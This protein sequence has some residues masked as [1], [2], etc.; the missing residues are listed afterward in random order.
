MNPIEIFIAESSKLFRNIPYFI[1]LIFDYWNPNL[2]KKIGHHFIVPFVKK[3]SGYVE[4]IKVPIELLNVYLPA[5]RVV[6]NGKIVDIKKFGEVRELSFLLNKSANTPQKIKEIPKLS[7]YFKRIFKE[8]FHKE[9]ERQWV[10]K[11][12]VGENIYYFPSTIIGTFFYFLSH[13]FTTNLF[14][15]SLSRE[16]I[17][18]GTNP[19]FIQLKPGYSNQYRE[20]VSLYLYSTNPEAKENYDSIG[21]RHIKKRIYREQDNKSNHQ[22]AFKCSFPVSG[23]WELK[24]RVLPIAD[25]SFFVAEILYV[26]TY[27]L[28]KTDFIELRVKSFR[29]R[30]R[31]LF[32]SSVVKSKT[33]KVYDSNKY[34]AV[35]ELPE[36]VYFQFSS[37][38]ADK[39]VNIIRKEVEDEDGNLFFSLIPIPRQIN[40]KKVL[41]N[42]K[43]QS[44]NGDAKGLRAKIGEK[45]TRDTENRVFDLEIVKELMDQVAKV[46]GVNMDYIEFIPKISVSADPK[47]QLELCYPDGNRRTVGVFFFDLSINKKVTA[48]FL[49]QKSLRSFITS[50]IIVGK[51]RLEYPKEVEFFFRTFVKV[52]RKSF[53]DFCHKK[54]FNVHLKKPIQGNSRKDWENWVERMVDILE[55][56]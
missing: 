47:K 46:L 35:E 42:V 12:S 6:Y 53:K 2:D 19:P 44:N 3:R 55:L 17:S 45:A 20:V 22:Y 23:E 16:I 43:G 38:P 36:T 39:S 25:K 49:D 48:I 11:V 56:E 7:N 4:P 5:Q 14:Q 41:S 27:K 26:N 31:L 8:F 24:A 21:I 51:R 29:K 50:P 40:D 54:G 10:I 1:P 9:V 34:S 30:K 33:N 52:R 37:P 18:F 13:K 28:L 32:S 15:V